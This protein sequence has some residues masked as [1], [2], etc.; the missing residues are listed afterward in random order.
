[1]TAL[2]KKNIHKQ[3]KLDS[4]NPYIKCS[5]SSQNDLIPVSYVTLVSLF[6]IK[7]DTSKTIC[8][9]MYIFKKGFC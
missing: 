4:V 7:K 6:R 9:Y 8:L 2:R 5:N 1:M 3:S